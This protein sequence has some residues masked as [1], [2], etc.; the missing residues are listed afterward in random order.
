MTKSSK[1][2]RLTKLRLC[3]ILSFLVIFLGGF[4]LGYNLKQERKNPP[5]IFTKT[6]SPFAEITE[7]KD[8]HLYGRLLHGRIK[9]GKETFIKSGD[10]SLDIEQLMKKSDLSLIKEISKPLDL[11]LAQK[12]GIL[13]VGSKSSR[14]L[15]DIDSHHA[16]RIAPENRVFVRNLKEAKKLGFSI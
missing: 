7:I 16:L 14:K 11:E 10:F 4:L 13:F 15:H 12:R 3:L 8:R 5:Q 1:S 9:V 2:S 6:K